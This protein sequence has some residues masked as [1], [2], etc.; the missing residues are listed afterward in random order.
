MSDH[1]PGSGALVSVRGLRF[2]Y[3][4]SQRDVLRVPFLD[5]PARGMTAITGPS[6][7]GKSTLIEL[8]AGTLRG[9]YE[10]SIEVLG[11]EWKTLSRDA[12]RQRQLRRIGLIP[13]DYGLLHNRTSKQM[14]DQD[15]IDAG[16][17]PDRRAGRIHD[18]L[19]AVGLTDVAD[20]AIAGL[21]GGQRQRVAIA[22]MLARQVDLVIADEPT[23]NLDPALTAG[24]MALFRRLAQEIPVV[25]ITHDPQVADACD[26]MIVL[27]ATV[28][29]LSQP[30]A[31]APALPGHA[32]PRRARRSVALAAT[33]GI[34]AIAA[35]IVISMAVSAKVPTPT[36]TSP[37]TAPAQSPQATDAISAAGQPGTVM[38]KDGVYVV[39]VDIQPGIY[40][41]AGASPCCQCYYALLS[42]TNT[43]DV[44]DNNSVTGQATIT[45]GARVKAVQVSSCKPWQKAS[46]AGQPGT[47][48]PNDGV[49]VVGVDIQP[50]IYHTAGAGPGGQCYYALLSST[51]TKDVIDNNS[52][53]GQATITVGARVKAVQVSSCKA[54]QKVG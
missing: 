38:P 42:S 41:T 49:Y 48:M 22:R 7:A 23:A 1:P 19:A 15:L 44:I 26:R 53:T 16:V 35:V 54:W 14:L 45:V 39:G 47:V 12:D 21:S 51:N 5:V 9:P 30:P 31:E 50:G 32:S 52:V 20:R 27:Q 25:I 28:E 4:G 17:S 34:L 24:A 43:K 40:H 18:A 11:T 2:R 37:A 10:G 6:G 8:L 13:Q 46:A 36:P 29:A 3:P 33:A